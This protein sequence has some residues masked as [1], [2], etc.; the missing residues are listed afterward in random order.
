MDSK[1]IKL[2]EKEGKR[3]ELEL[4]ESESNWFMIDAAFDIPGLL[5]SGPLED[6]LALPNNWEI[7]ERVVEKGLIMGI[8]VY[9]DYQDNGMVCY[10]AIDSLLS[11][12]GEYKYFIITE[13]TV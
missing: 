10:S 4:F 8:P 5:F 9:D 7:A 6:F 11:A 3:Y 1:T 2:S 13:V 12:V